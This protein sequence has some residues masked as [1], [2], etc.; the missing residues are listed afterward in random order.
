VYQPPDSYSSDLQI[1]LSFPRV[2]ALLKRFQNTVTHKNVQPAGFLPNSSHITTQGRAPSQ[3]F[4][5][6]GSQDLPAVG[7]GA[8][9]ESQQSFD[10]WINDNAPG[11]TRSSSRSRLPIGRGVSP[12][13]HGPPTT[14]AGGGPLPKE[15]SHK[16]D[17]NHRGARRTRGGA[18]VNAPA[19]GNPNGQPPPP[20]NTWITQMPFTPQH[21]RGTDTNKIPWK[22]VAC[23]GAK[24]IFQGLHPNVCRMYAEFGACSRFNKEGGRSSC[25]ATWHV[26]VHPGTRACYMPPSPMIIPALENERRNGKATMNM[27]VSE[28]VLH[29]EQA[30]Q[31]KGQEKVTNHKS[32][33][34][35]NFL[36]DAIAMGRRNGKP[37][38]LEQAVALAKAGSQVKEEFATDA[39]ATTRKRR[40]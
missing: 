28:F 39:D 3:P 12:P 8:R 13:A 25:A 36:A 7:F 2:S 29:R 22:R 26:Y 30:R 34:V 16:E 35:A 37:L 9:E 1:L 38:S 17:P 20:L 21:P 23:K 40:R 33:E 31:K 5:G 32:T 11:D 4:N 14:P 18:A 10:R 27:T 19:G 24:C 6:A 15:D